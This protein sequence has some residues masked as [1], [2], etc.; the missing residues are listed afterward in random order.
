[1]QLMPPANHIHLTVDG[2]SRPG[3]HISGNVQ[4]LLISIIFILKYYTANT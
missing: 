4:L 1:V 3:S 2:D